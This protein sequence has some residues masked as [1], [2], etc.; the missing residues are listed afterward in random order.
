MP[1]QRPEYLSRAANGLRDELRAQDR[2]TLDAIAARTDDAD[3]PL[4]HAARDLR[5]LQASLDELLGQRLAPVKP[6][7][8]VVYGDIEPA[9]HGPY[10]TD[11]ERREAARAISIEHGVYRLDGPGPVEVDDF[12]G[13]ELGDR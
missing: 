6:F 1:I 5:A 11:C 7:L 4:G 10:E 12:T 9:I 3:G 8:L 13:I 2:S